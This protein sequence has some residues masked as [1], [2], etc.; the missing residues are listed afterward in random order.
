[1]VLLLFE[2]HGYVVA[3]HA[4]FTPAP[5]EEP[6][7]RHME[8][9]QAHWGEMDTPSEFMAKFNAFGAYTGQPRNSELDHLVD[10]GK[11]FVFRSAFTN[12]FSVAGI[13]AQEL[14]FEVARKVLL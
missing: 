6:P 11:H 8:G 10:H 9:L 7:L 1:M 2:Y 5:K 13:E 12:D 4:R 14:A 3:V